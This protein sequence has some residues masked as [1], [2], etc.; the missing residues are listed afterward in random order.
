M[1][2]KLH[3]NGTVRIAEPIAEVLDGW[4]AGCRPEIGVGPKP[5]TDPYVALLDAE[6]EKREA[7]LA[8]IEN[9][10]SASAGATLR[11]CLAVK[12]GLLTA[13]R[14]YTNPPRSDV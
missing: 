4:L 9:D 3:K 5:V 1:S 11:W 8:D 14:L 6:I 7:A 2:A 10:N 12:H 13:R